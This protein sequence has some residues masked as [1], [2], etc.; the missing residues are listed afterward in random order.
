MEVDSEESQL[1]ISGALFWVT[2]SPKSTITVD[3]IT[4]F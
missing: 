4:M 3:T 1:D 2:G